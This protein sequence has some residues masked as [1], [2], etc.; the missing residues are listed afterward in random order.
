MLKSIIN[1]I[2]SE[3]V[4]INS[5]KQTRR[6]SIVRGLFGSPKKII[7]DEDIY[8]DNS[9]DET[10]TTTTTTNHKSKPL[11]KSSFNSNKSNR[12]TNKYLNY[13]KRF[14]INKSKTSSQRS[15]TEIITTPVSSNSIPTTV[16]EDDSENK[17][18][19]LSNFNKINTNMELLTNKLKNTENELLL[20]KQYYCLCER[21]L[22]I[23]SVENMIHQ[24]QNIIIDLFYADYCVLYDEN[25]NIKITDPLVNVYIL[26]IYRNYIYNI[27]ELK[28]QYSL[29]IQLINL[30]L[31][32]YFQ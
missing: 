17:L 15:M 13:D 14:Q 19:E 25:D 26:L 3:E 8:E 12:S 29:K 10:T 7:T 11:S 16:I 2:F 4:I 5:D 27:K 20:W 30:K 9:D 23:N 21:L 22:K 32:V 1:N 31:L 24:I 28:H 6:A 18:M